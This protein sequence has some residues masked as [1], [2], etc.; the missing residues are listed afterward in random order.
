MSIR[1]YHYCPLCGTSLE[2]QFAFH[3][4]RSVCPA[5]GF[6][7]FHDPKVAVIGMVTWGRR[8]LLIRRGVDPMKGRWALP[9]GYMDAGEMPAEALIRELHEEVG[10]EVE[11]SALLDIFPMAGPGVFNSGIVIA[12]RA[13]IDRDEIDRDEAPP[14]ACDDDACEAAWFSADE[15]PAELA[16]EST[17]TLLAQWRAEV[18][19]I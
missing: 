19:N 18:H 13:E 6:V 1:K 9:G 7:H 8:V 4:M 12:Y 2:E 3:Q 14:L 10:L 15:L 17:Q 5:C 11:V 16:F